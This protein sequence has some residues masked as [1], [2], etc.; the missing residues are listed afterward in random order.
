MRD[1]TCR[2]EQLGIRILADA[3]CGSNQAPLKQKLLAADLAQDINIQLM[4]GILQPYVILEAYNIDECRASEVENAVLEA[5]ECFVREGL[6]HVQLAATLANLEFQMRERNYGRMPQGIVFGMQVL[7]S[8]LYGGDPAANLE[9]EALFASLNRKLEDG[10]FECLLERVFLD[11][12]H[13]CQ[14]LL[15]P[16]ATLGEEKRAAEESRLYTARES[17]S[18]EDIAA[19]QKRQEALISWQTSTDTPE[20]VATLPSL[21]L[22]DI[23]IQPER[24]PAEERSLAGHLL[25][26]HNIPTGGISYINLYFDISDFSQEKLPDIS[27]LCRL[28]GSLDTDVHSTLHLQKLC[29]LNMGS[30]GFSVEAYGGV[31][32]P[33]TCRTFLCVS[34]SAL[35]TKLE[36]A[37]S[38]VTEIITGTSFDNQRLIREL[39][40]QSITEMEQNII[41]SG[42]DFAMTRIGAGYSAEGVVW[43]CAEGFT[44]CQRLKTLEKDF[45][46][47]ASQLSQELA[48]LYRE[49]FVKNRLTISITDI[50]NNTEGLLKTALISALPTSEQKEFSCAIHP[51]GA[52]REG[53]VI[54]ADISF[55]ALGG[56]LLHHGGAYNGSLRVLSRV[57]SLAYLWNV[58]RVQGGAYG[59]G[60][61]LSYSGNA[62]FYSYRDPNAA[63]SLKCFRQVADFVNQFCSAKPDLTGFVVG[64]VAESDPLMRPRQQGKVSDSLYLKGVSY[65]DRCDIRGE[66]LSVTPEVLAGLAQP[67]CESANNGSVCVIGSHRQIKACGKAIDTIY[68]L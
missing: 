14:V 52:R 54:P 56:N 33:E 63:R 61:F 21:Q 43:E 22:S 24:I 1:F 46:S 58:I 9:V 41:S 35:D 28:L 8:W 48:A 12:P 32:A 29:R 2:E 50:N 39:L 3:L 31:N 13:R 57:V 23:S 7:E 47:N 36:S 53:I 60:F 37:A 34:F 19:L 44:Y 51:W 18:A 62:S 59:A 65:A 42:S 67:L 45:E 64:A 30:I 25:L 49:I 4:D 40:R 5:L 20:A 6:D 10:W 55:A 27:F 16:S 26:R 15:L 11:N 68:T 66:M 38:L 17:W